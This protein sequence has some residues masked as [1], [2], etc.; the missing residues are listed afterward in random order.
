MPEHMPMNRLFA[1]FVALFLMGSVLYG[2]DASYRNLDTRECPILD[3]PYRT[4]SGFEVG[5]ELPAP[6]DAAGW[7]DLSVYE[8]DA[9]VRCIDWETDFG[10]DLEIQAQWNTL[11]LQMSEDSDVY[12]LTRAGLFLQWSQRF[13]DGYG[14]QVN[15]T[16]GLYSALQSDVS[17]KD[18]SVP[19]GVVGIKALSPDFALFAGVRVYPDFQQPVD[20][21]V[22]LRWSYR[23]DVLLQLGYPESRLEYSPVRPLRFVTAARLWLWP[24]YSMGDDV[25]ERLRFQEGRVLGGIEWACTEHTVFSL[26]GGYLFDRRISFE[27]S[28]PDVRIDDA[29][30]VMIGISGRL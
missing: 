20:P 30:F 16:P 7:G 12:S 26:T 4:H 28:S 11:V 17:G 8:V 9:W 6:T 25:R 10:G 27:S 13:I 15:A 22:G 21:V 2:E 14:M 18:F 19:F 23:D 24:D 3:T 5:Y 1:S 29:P